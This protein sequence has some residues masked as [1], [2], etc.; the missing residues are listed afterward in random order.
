M[1]G[2]PQFDL[3]G[4]Y[5]E[6]RDRLIAL[7]PTLS[8]AQLST[9]TPTC[10]EWT[11]QDIY[12]HLTGL[13]AEVA[14]GR[15]EG[16]GT[17]ERTA[18]QVSSRRGRTIGEI[19]EEWSLVG[20]EV[21]AFIAESGRAL[22]PLAIDVWTH[23]QDIANGAGVE[24]GRDGSG[25]WVALNAAWA[26]K[27]KLRNAGLAPLRLVA[28]DVNWVIGDGEP[29]ATIS[30]DVYEAARAV[31]GRRSVEQ[32]RRYRWEGDPEPYLPH[33]PVFDPPVYDVVE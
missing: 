16:R 22:T 11:V 21:D 8:P 33:L 1:T 28:G 13:A 17:P 12:A 6:T 3:P 23:E 15:I 9:L 24:S 4:I 5:R 14:A 2:R 25:L 19:C 32:M 10:P 26:M 29:G 18:V 7:A 30:L 31:M 20:P 27:A